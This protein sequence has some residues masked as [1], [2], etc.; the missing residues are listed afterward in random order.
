MQT[1]YGLGRLPARDERDR[2]FLLMEHPRAQTITKVLD[3]TWAFF[4]RPLDQGNTGTCVGHGWKHCL[5]AAPIVR[6]KDDKPS[7]FDI[8]DAAIKVDEFPDN[9]NDT[10]RQM[11]TS[12][13]AGAKVLQTLGLLDEYAWIT[14]ADE[15]SRWIGGVDDKGK[16]VGSP[17][18]IGV[19]WYESMFETDKEGILKISGQVAGGHCVCVNRWLPKRGLFGAIQ[20]WALPWGIN[21]SG[22]F[23]LRAEDLGRLLSEDGEGCTPT[24]SRKKLGA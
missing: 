1:P 17:I 12:V 5:M 23:Y 16:F 15:A 19:N 11:G 3:K 2:R 22:H 9:D 10:D 7:P 21:G 18:V 20:N 8:Y 4:S 24:E 14:T 13:R 6:K